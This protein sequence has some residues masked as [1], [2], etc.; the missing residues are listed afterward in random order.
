ML[1]GYY[2]NDKKIS[3]S[4][5][6]HYLYKVCKI[7]ILENA[8]SVQEVKDIDKLAIEKM[9][10]YFNKMKNEAAIIEAKKLKF[11]IIP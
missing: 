4:L 7:L 2:L 1:R 10:E 5:F 3:Y 9:Q 8:E 11:Q 6:R